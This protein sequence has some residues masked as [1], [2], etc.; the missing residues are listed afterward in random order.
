MLEKIVES[1]QYLMDNF[2]DAQ[3]VKSYLNSRI[4]I[5]SQKL[6]QFGYFPTINNLR[7]L[8]DMIGEDTLKDSGLL[9]S[10]SIEDSMCPR[11]LNTSYFD[12]YP[13]IM[14][15]KNSYGNIVA[16]VG[17]TLLSDKEQKESNISKYKNTR[18]TPDFKKGNLLFGLYENKKFILEQ[19]AVYVV[20][21]QFDVI[22]AVERGFR[23]IVALGSFSMSTYQFCLI[24]RYTTNI[25]LLLDN[26]EAGERG[27]KRIIDK[28]GK[29]ANIQN[30][31]LPADYKDIDE[32]L[33]KTGDTSMSFSLKI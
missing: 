29:F 1:C 17:R 31:Y 20:E 13:L 5:E 7:S 32:Y 9:F 11:I 30:F 21:G 3:D 18:E 22:K 28:F 25:F 33:T 10:R 26:D 2:P 14:P 16:L 6:F 15:F 24:N 27:R 12:N 4:S 19:D 23:N 8:T